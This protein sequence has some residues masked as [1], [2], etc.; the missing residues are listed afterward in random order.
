[1]VLASNK[2]IV[3]PVLIGREKDLAALQTC[4]E[5]TKRGEGLVA[6]IGGEAGVGKSRLVEETKTYAADQGFVLM[7]GNC[8]QEDRTFPYAPFL[9]LLRTYFSG[10]APLMRKNDLT[11]F[12]QELSQFLPDV[13]PLIPERPPLILAPSVD[14]QQEQRHLFALLLHFFTEQATRQPLLCILEDL[15]WSD[16]TS[17]ELLVYLTRNCRHL[18]LLFVLTYR[19][20]EVSPELRHCLAEF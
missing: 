12:A 15:H 2:S 11:P 8:F 16:E 20:D 10:T 1:M 17:L 3:C 9:G 18:P 5:Q 14:P 13:T 6:L 19:S 4:L 7:Q